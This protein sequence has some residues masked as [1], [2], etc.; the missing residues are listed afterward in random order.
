MGCEREGAKILYVCYQLM[1]EE[2]FQQ[3]VPNLID[4][5]LGYCNL[6]Y[7]FCRALCT[8]YVDSFSKCSIL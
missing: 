6:T 7:I 8:L 5:C 3:K 4:F 2:I 1:I